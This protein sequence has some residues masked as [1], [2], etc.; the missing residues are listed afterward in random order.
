MVFG[1]PFNGAPI[2]GYPTSQIKTYCIAGDE[3]CEVEF[4]ITSSHL[5]YTLL[6]TTEA[7]A[8][9]ESIV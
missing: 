4:V 2:K 3:V 7:V 5:S 1:D 8:Y 9:I 6:G